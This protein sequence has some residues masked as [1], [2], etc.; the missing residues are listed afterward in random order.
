MSVAAWIYLLLISTA[1]MLTILNPWAGLIL[2][3]LILL[4]LLFHGATTRQ[5]GPRRFLITLTLAPLIRIL[6]ISLPLRGFP[7]IFWYLAIG[8][9]LFLAALAAL[10]VTALSA[11]RIGLTVK[12]WP[13]EAGIALIGIALGLMEYFILYPRPLI[14]RWTWGDFLL[15][16]LI[17]L[18]FTG[19]LEEL[20]F[21]GL[22]QETATAML[23][24]AGLIYTALLFAMM[25]VGYLSLA[26]VLFVFGVGLLFGLLVART[27]SLVGVSLAHALT[28]IGL[29]LVY[30]F[31]FAGLTT[32]PSTPAAPQEILLPPVEVPHFRGR[33]VTPTPTTVNLIAPAPL[34]GQPT[35]SDK[36]PR[37][38]PL[39]TP[40]AASCG[41][42]ALGESCRMQPGNVITGQNRIPNLSPTEHYQANDLSGKAIPQP[43]QALF[44]PAP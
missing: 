8:S 23:G 24:R 7:L 19:I 30:P 5:T 26:D 11:R 36:H 35:T 22:I 3:S 14:A 21:R 33:Y 4:A 1:E 16:A 28:N 29:Y 44:L 27:R 39:A 25:H 40:A 31:L 18:V 43:A 41:T 6:S 2:H 12:S 42:V 15:A 17:L 34:A 10:R 13:A 32:T 38:M 37:A 20:I 9:L